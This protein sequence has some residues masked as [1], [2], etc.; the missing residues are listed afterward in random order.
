MCSA[1]QIF[2]SGLMPPATYKT[3]VAPTDGTLAPG[4]D[5]IDHGT[6]LANVTDG[7]RGAAPDLGAQE[8][9]CAVPVYGVRP[10]GVDESN[11][12]LGCASSPAG[13]AGIP[14]GEGGVASVDGGALGADGGP[15]SVGGGGAGGPGSDPGT[16][17]RRLVLPRPRTPRRDAA[18]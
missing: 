3:V 6:L 18:A 1:R 13:D 16:A 5:A 9:G 12:T 2:A 15:I 4:S 7:F 10:E 17:G 11:E 14:E 8:T